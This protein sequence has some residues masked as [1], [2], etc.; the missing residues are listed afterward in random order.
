M[1][2]LLYFINAMIYHKEISLVYEL[3]HAFMF[4]PYLTHHGCVSL[5]VSAY[6]GLEST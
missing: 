1:I 5:A 4:W 6:Q 2:T 3:F